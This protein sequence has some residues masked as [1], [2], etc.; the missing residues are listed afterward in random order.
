MQFEDFFRNAKSRIVIVGTHPLT[1]HLESSARFFTDLLTL[2]TELQITILAE[3][4]S[5]CF[6]QALCVDTPQS[7]NR[8][9]FAALLV[10][11][12]RVIGKSDRDGIAAAMK[13][14]LV[15]EGN[16]VAESVLSRFVVKQSNLRLPVNI[17]TADGQI[18]T[19]LTTHCMP[20]IDSYELVP[21]E[22]PLHGELLDFL[23]FYTV[24]E[25]GGKYL[26][27]PGQELIQMYDRKG[28]PRGIYPRACFYTT[29]YERYSVWGFV[30][31]RKGQLL[32]HQRSPYPITKDGAGL[33]DKSVG[34]HVDLK[35]SSTSITAE[36]E[37]IEEMFLPEA[38][39]T[40]YVQADMGDIIHFGEWNPSKRP[41]SA[42]L[43]EIGNL[44]PAD[45]V[46]FRA[47]DEN[48]QPLTISRVSDR[49]FA[50]DDGAVTWRRTVFRSDVYLFIAP[51]DYLDT[52]EQMK[53]LLVR[54]EGSGAAKDHKLVSIGDLRD[55]IA[56]EESKSC[57]RDIFT[58]DILFVNLRYRDMLEGFAEFVNYLGTSKEG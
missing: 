44:A 51:V 38:E 53:N 52:L 39:Y 4:D 23:D 31:N 15:K 25:K 8:R 20:T 43:G 46:M 50:S 10:H 47:T 9:S 58:D 30:F 1:P 33:W 40:K 36:R 55:W 24:S 21:V 37:L 29:E 16:P 41:E 17:I 5:E 18:W 26:S 48:G 13:K 57:E 6:N 14:E 22:S 32:L 27:S 54:A 19:C 56:A 42:F 12:D 34:G 2:N 45:W 35:D 7:S 28:I 3:S 11:R 49:R